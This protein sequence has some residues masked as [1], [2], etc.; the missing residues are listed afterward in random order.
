MEFGPPKAVSYTHLDVYKRQ[1]L[2]IP[3]QTDLYGKKADVVLLQY[4][5]PEQTFDNMELLKQQINR[6]ICA[7]REYREETER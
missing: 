2:D 1:L 7:A 3:P 4:L 5:R 6:D